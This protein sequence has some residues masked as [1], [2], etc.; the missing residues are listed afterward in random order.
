MTATSSA[1][2]TDPVSVAV[3]S[4][5][6]IA[7]GDRADFDPLYRP[8]AVDRENQ[9]QPPSSRVP[10]PAASTQPRCGCAPH[11]PACTTTSTTP[12]P[13]ATWSR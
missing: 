9:V 6:A 13:T 8:R 11:L 2:S 10:G 5:H 7:A 3:R 1:V 12:S 4:I